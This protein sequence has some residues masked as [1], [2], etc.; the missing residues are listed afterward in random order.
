MINFLK[1]LF[2]RH[3]KLSF[4]CNIYGDEINM[5]NCRSLWKCKRCGHL[6]KGEQLF[7]YEGGTP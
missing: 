7:D 2:C 3:H 6:V 5:L 1:R 4:H